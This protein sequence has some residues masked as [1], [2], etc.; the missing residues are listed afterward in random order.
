M[1]LRAVAARLDGVL[2]ETDAYET[3]LIDVGRLSAAPMATPLIASADRLVLV[4]RPRVEE[5]QSLAHRLDVVAR[6]GP[7]PELLL[8]GERPYGP[9][10]IAATL[11][12]PVLGV[13]AHDP[14]AADALGAVAAVRRLGRSLLLRSAVGVVER[15]TRQ[16][17]APASAGPAWTSGTAERA[18]VVSVNGADAA[19]SRWSALRRP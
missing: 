4:A 12:C 18:P 13:L 1:L 5:L 16:R 17:T 15:L 2:S 9:E 14:G 6:I 7:P 11:G 19:S 8:I 10:E 3:V